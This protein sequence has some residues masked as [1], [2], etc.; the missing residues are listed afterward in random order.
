MIDKT[1]NSWRMDEKEDVEQWPKNPDADVCAFCGS[2]NVEPFISL[3]FTSYRYD[4]NIPKCYQLYP[5]VVC[6]YCLENIKQVNT[7][8]KRILSPDKPISYDRTY[9]PNRV[10]PKWRDEIRKNVE[11]IKSSITEI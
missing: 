3:P 6:S 1:T 8:L 10:D 2:E 4:W 5:T 7:Y 11:R 9:S